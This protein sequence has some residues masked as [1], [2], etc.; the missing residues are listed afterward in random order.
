MNFSQ[1][2]SHAQKLVAVSL[3]LGMTSVVACV[4]TPPGDEDPSE[5]VNDASSEGVTEAEESVAESESALWQG[6][7]GCG[8]DKPICCVRKDDNGDF[9]GKCSDLQSDKYNCGSCGH[10][11]PYKC[12]DGECTG[13]VG[14]PF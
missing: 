13:V 2:M 14:T 10:V 7:G 8:S 1:L 3:W 4:A 5:E 6:C 11:C 9:Y 12:K